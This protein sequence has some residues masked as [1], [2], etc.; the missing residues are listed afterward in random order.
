MNLS[1][2]SMK[3]LLDLH[4]SIA[5]KPATPKTFATKAKLIERIRSIQAAQGVTTAEPEASRDAK[6]AKA[7]RTTRKKKEAKPR[8]M[9]I[10]ALARELLMDPAGHVHSRIAEMINERIEGASATAQ[11]IRWYATKM[12]AD[13]I[14]VPERVAAPP[15]ANMT[16][17]RAA[18]AVRATK[19]V[20]K[21][22]KR[23]AK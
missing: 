14:K 7:P 1:D 18:K 2:M 9:G 4:N 5:A 15:E 10:G 16:G 21:G 23:G 17:E 13:G 22:A 19:R 6:P 3:D 20:K 12:R 8:G 11:S